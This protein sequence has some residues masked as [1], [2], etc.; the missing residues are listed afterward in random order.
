[1]GY[2]ISQLPEY[3]SEQSREFMVKSILGAQTLDLL[4]SAGS[5]NPN[6]KGSEAVQLMAND[7]VFQDGNAHGRNPQGN[8]TL[9]Q[10]ILTVKPIKMQMNLYPRDLEATYGVEDLKAKMKGQVYDDALFVE[11]I[12][13]D[14]AEQVKHEIEKLTW[15]GDT[16]ATGN[17]KFAD[18]FIK[19]IKAGTH[20][21]LASATGTTV[22]KKLQGVFAKMPVAITSKPDFRI[23]IGTDMY[24]AY[25]AELAEKN[26]FTAQAE[27]VLFGTTAKLAVVDGLIG[28][29]TV[30]ASRLRNLR[31]G[32]ELQDAAL[33]K[34][35]S[36]ETES[37]NLDSRFSIGYTVVYPFEVGIVT[38]A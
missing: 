16:T 28:T 33:D 23:F 15:V 27:G 21:D 8:T 4:S 31:A 11:S 29:N 25:I 13:N 38:Y 7:V 30:V 14:V 24:N 36:K 20:I 22:T 12:G 10:A 18:G 2:N 1:M 35:Y 32:G 6:A 34:W 17:M 26:L 5:F 9:S 19:T 37:V 3:T